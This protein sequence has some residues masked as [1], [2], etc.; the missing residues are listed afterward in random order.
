MK[1]GIIMLQNPEPIDML[2]IIRISIQDYIKTFHEIIIRKDKI[3]KGKKIYHNERIYQYLAALGLAKEYDYEVIL[4]NDIKWKGLSKNVDI[5]L[6]EN[7]K[8]IYLMEFKIWREQPIVPHEH[9][10]FNLLK[11]DEFIG[12]LFVVL[13]IQHEDN[14]NKNENDLKTKIRPGFIKESIE[15]GNKLTFDIYGFKI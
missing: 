14:I 8:P 2:R 3:Y 10:I 5:A 13:T 1:E 9:D 7:D 4:D 15:L 12:K 11:Y 6:F